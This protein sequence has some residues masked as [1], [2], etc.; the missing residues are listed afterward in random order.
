MAVT[1]PVECTIYTVTVSIGGHF[2][3]GACVQLQILTRAEFVS[4]AVVEDIQLESAGA[5][6]NSR[7]QDTANRESTHSTVLAQN[8]QRAH[9]D[10]IQ[11]NLYNVMHDRTSC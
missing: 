10:I 8:I 1:F 3:C 2:H 6:V 4:K 7:Q 9:I 5:F 11:Y